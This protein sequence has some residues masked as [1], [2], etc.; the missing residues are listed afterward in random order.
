MAV[1]TKNFKDATGI[2]KSTADVL[3]TLAESFREPDLL[4]EMAD[5]PKLIR[6]QGAG[7]VE[8]MAQCLDDLVGDIEELA[9]NSRKRQG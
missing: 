9:S 1:E 2:V 6:E 7:A 3:R 5:A 4:R 8:F